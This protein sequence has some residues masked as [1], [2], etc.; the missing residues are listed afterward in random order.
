MGKEPAGFINHAC[1]KM[2]VDSSVVVVFV[3]LSVSLLM[4]SLGIHSLYLSPLCSI[5]PPPPSPPPL[6][7]SWLEHCTIMAS[8]AQSIT[9]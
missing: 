8:D 6:F 1:G 9:A 2:E 7:L 5:L 3:T 4:I